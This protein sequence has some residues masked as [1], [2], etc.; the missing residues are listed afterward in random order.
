MKETNKKAGF[1]LIISLSQW[2]YY[3]KQKKRGIKPV[4]VTGL[5]VKTFFFV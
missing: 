4:A 1:L 5:I 2:S 3:F